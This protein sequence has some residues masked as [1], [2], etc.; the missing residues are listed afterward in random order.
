MAYASLEPFG[1]ERADV[2]AGI[3]AAVIANANRDRKKRPDPFT[4]AD[5]M[6]FVKREPAGPL[7]PDALTEMV[8]QTFG[9]PKAKKKGR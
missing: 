9:H 1:E 2:R 8:K 3:I 6:P 4:P 5:F 7:S